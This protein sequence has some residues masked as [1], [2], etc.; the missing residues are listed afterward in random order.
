M[1]F[2]LKHSL[3]MAMGKCFFTY[4]EFQQTYTSM[5][6][7]LGG[8]LDNLHRYQ[9]WACV[10]LNRFSSAVWVKACGLGF[11]NRTENQLDN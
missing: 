11:E 5:R 2:F 6:T 3:Y 9:V 4:L 10:I 8:S 1:V 7:G